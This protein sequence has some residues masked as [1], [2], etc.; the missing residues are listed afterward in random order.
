LRLILGDKVNQKG[1][2]VEPDKLRFDF[3]HDEAVSKSNLDQVEALV[4]K[5]ILGNSEVITEETDIE[6][7]KKK[8]AMALFGEKYGESVRVL[9]MGDN[10]FSVELCGGTH[11]KRLGDIGRFKII[12]ESGVASGVRRIEAVTGLEAYKLDKSN[13]DNLDMIA[14][15][16]KSN[17]VNLLEKIRQLISNQKSLEK[18]IENFQKQLASTQSGD[19][20]SKADDINGIKLLATEVS[21]VSAKDL[22]DLADKLKDRLGTAVVVL[23]VVSGKKVSLISAVTKNLTDKYQAGTILNHVASQIGGKGGG[24]ADMAQGGGTEPEKLTDALNSVQDLIG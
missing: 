18:Q 20:L 19:L 2:L 3:S 11:V 14:S 4:N 13:E 21:G 12:S 10:N 8:G 16:T 15:L 24:R 17:S 23:A 22:R 9:S 7:A 1:S 5:Q 6:T